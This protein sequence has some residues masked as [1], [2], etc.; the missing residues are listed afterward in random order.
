MLLH[1]N[2]A[3]V[4]KS[5]LIFVK[6][7]TAILRLSRIPSCSIR[8]TFAHRSFNN[9]T[10]RQKYRDIEEVLKSKLNILT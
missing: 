4:L 3:W 7:R 8:S 10:S 6:G 1:I 5:G 9:I 2:W